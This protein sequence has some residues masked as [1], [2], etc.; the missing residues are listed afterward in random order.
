MLCV[1]VLISITIGC[2][3]RFLYL[4]I[5]V[6]YPE[7]AKQYMDKKQPIEKRMEAAVAIVKRAYSEVPSYEAIL[8][9]A[10]KVPLQK[11]HL[12]CTLQPGIPVSPM[13]AKP[14][15]SVQ[16]VLKRLNGLDFTVRRNAIIVIFL[17]R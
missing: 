17:A 9:A 7:E 2:S 10:V 5:K 4:L 6:I 14:T 13:L 8:E 16:E 1:R 11:F 15:K 12:E 3:F